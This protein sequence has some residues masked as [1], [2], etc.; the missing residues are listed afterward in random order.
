MSKLSITKRKLSFTKISY[1]RK[2]K[3]KNRITKISLNKTL[4]N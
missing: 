3:N 4:T 1:Y 2:N